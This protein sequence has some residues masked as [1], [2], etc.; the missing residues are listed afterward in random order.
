[1]QLK[2]LSVM[3]AGGLPGRTANAGTPELVSLI[4]GKK[5][6]A[7]GLSSRVDSSAQ[8]CKININSSCNGHLVSYDNNSVFSCNLAIISRCQTASADS[9][10][11]ANLK[12]S[13]VLE[14]KYIS[15]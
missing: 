14:S 2:C 8:G 11:G 12:K 15:E 3:T 13:W 1:M 7:S 10:R 5:L 6:T 4:H 9:T